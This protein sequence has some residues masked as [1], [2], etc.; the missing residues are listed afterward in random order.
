MSIRSY[1]GHDIETAD[2]EVYRASVRGRQNKIAHILED[3]LDHLAWKN[4]AIVQLTVLGAN[5]GWFI[6]F[7]VD[8]RDVVAGSLMC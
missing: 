1:E 3:G 8:S 6:Y 4:T 7:E 2:S 5:A